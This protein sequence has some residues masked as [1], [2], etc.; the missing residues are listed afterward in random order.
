[1]P[2]EFGGKCF[3]TLDAQVPSSYPAIRGIQREVNKISIVK[4]NL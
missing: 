2:S 1:M 3:F 4:D